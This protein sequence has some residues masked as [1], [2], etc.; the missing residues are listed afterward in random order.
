MAAAKG[1]PPQLLRSVKSEHPTLAITSAASIDVQVGALF[2]CN[3][4]TLDPAIR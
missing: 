2:G 4:T 1:C 3:P